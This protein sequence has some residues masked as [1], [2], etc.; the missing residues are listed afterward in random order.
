MS[1]RL[2]RLV[3]I[4]R[5]DVLVRLRRPSTAVLFVLISIIPYIWI[6]DPASGRALMQ[7]AE[8]RVLY[9]S[10]A[11]GMATAVLATMFIGLAGFYVISNALRRDVVS[12]CGFVIASTTMRGS[13]YLTG[14]FL[15]NAAFL[16]LFTLGFM[17]T[18]MAMV[19]VRG[20]AALEPFVFARQYALLLPPAIVFVSAAAILFECTPLL[21][22]RAGDVAYFFLWIG[23]MGS[24]AAM[25]QNGAAG[26]MA[27]YFD[28]AGLGFVFE[29]VK[30][31]YGVDSFSI[32]ASAFDA[33]R[34]PMVFAGLQPASVVPRVV[35]TVWPVSL[36][37][38][39]RLFFHRFDPARVRAVR[40]AQ[41]GASWLGR[42][43]AVA[44]PLSRRMVA[45]VSRADV[46]PD[47]LLRLAWIDAV[48]TMAAQP[49]AC[50]AAIG[51]AIAALAV[52][53]GAVF[54]GILP[55]AFAGCAVTIAEIACRDSRAGTSALVFAAPG[56]RAGFVAWKFTSSLLAGVAFLFVPLA[57]AIA[58]RPAA[59]PAL[60]IGL[61]FTVAAATALAVMSANAKAFLVA[62]LTF[63]Y[64]AISD[65]GSSTALDFAGWFG[66][67]TP[68][69]IAGYA[70]ASLTLLGAAQ[71]VHAWEL[72]R[73][74]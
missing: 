38:L 50:V 12:R 68:L 29:Q 71:L 11:I 47:G 9:D 5:A 53:A 64:I 33:T 51:F 6:S 40:S 19:L 45:L 24:V 15:G 44:R 49:L 60:L 54:T 17:T 16:S 55:L 1:A 70:V 25:L 3:A 73:R 23:G 18:A 66:T 74:W 58:I 21:R 14:K 30:S 7:I 34:T 52:D 31:Q 39:A 56:L 2:H 32:G 59:A 48:A 61:T 8:R 57:R 72:R 27:A 37:V 62:F 20:E 4:V 42:V 26:S 36:L 43:H 69:V 46:L 22:S 65:K 13:E 35:A 63:W 10:A 41:S 67:A 28:V